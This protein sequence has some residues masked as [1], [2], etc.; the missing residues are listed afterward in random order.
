M[1]YDINKDLL[2]V[3]SIVKIRFSKVQFMIIG[4]YM[5]D[6]NGIKHDY[7]A[8]EYPVGMHSFDNIAFFDRKLVKKVIN[9]GY[10][11]DRE[12]SFKQRLKENVNKVGKQETE[13]VD[14]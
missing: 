8:V 11:C 12:I 4:F 1:K 6:E 14:L 13:F 5:L 10:I 9:M 2:P 3:G 7:A